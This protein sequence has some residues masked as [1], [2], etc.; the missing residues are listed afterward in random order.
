MITYRKANESDVDILTVMRSHY[1]AESVELNSDEERIKLIEP[2][3]N[4][5]I[6]ALNNSFVS[7]LAL[8]GNE[9]IG[10]SGLITYTIPPPFKFKNGRIG[11]IMNLY[12]VPEHRKCGIGKELF[13]LTLEEAKS[14]DCYKVTLIAS[15]M[16]KY[17]YE[18]MGFEII[19]NYMQLWLKR[20]D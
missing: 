3:R 13:R 10:T 18:K 20:N 7:W 14:M 17:I 11:Y 19:N 12:V 16:G 1:I 4:Y 9:I 5:L 15:D 6:D 8:D 2:N